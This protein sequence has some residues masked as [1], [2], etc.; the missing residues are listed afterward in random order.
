MRL[1]IIALTLTSSAALGQTLALTTPNNET[2][3]RVPKQPCDLPR[4]VNWA[5][6]G[7]GPCSDLEF[8]IQK[9][10]TCDDK[11]PT[12][13]T[14]LPKVSLS[15]LANTRTGS[16]S[17]EVGELP[18]FSGTDAVSCPAD[19][20][21]DQYRLCAAVRQF[22]GIV[23]TECTATPQKDDLEVVYDAKPPSAPSLEDVQGLDQALSIRVAAPT[24][25]SE[26]TVTVERTDGTAF[27]R[28][29]TQ[30]ADQTL[31]RVE[32]LENNVTYRVT[33]RA[34]DA[35]ENESEPSAALEG[36]PIFT[37]GFF[38]RYVEANG[39]ETGGCG[40]AGMG[41]AGGWVLAVLGFWLSSRRNRS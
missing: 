31:F 15:T 35:A 22:G 5:Y 10:T 4:T 34:L 40:A 41:L 11:A 26:I 23:G 33:A 24:D 27:T 7:A 25:A 8:W 1:L 19:N 29:L 36:T 9:G 2:S 6:N 39:Q 16:I 3:L 20:R 30:S 17:F 13:A 14:G 28:T 18:G 12:G 37:K 38:D 21:E 32:R